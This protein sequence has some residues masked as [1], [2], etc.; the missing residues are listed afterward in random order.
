[1]NG[2]QE[3]KDRELPK[4]KQRI[5]TNSLKLPKQTIKN[6]GS[7]CVDLS[8]YSSSLM[9]IGEK[10][11]SFAPERDSLLK[12]SI[13]S[14]SVN[15][16][17]FCQNLTVLLE[18]LVRAKTGSEYKYTENPIVQI[19]S[20]SWSKKLFELVLEEGIP[21]SMHFDEE[22]LVS[23]VL[24]LFG[25]CLE[26]MKKSFIYII[27]SYCNKTQYLKIVLDEKGVPVSEK[28]KKVVGF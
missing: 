1:M 11:I 16:S 5:V 2:N 9:R 18:S 7:K 19:N 25:H 20:A 4:P 27:F 14:S 3:K 23:V 21:L 15:F 26:T 17:D 8:V 10:E 28:T 24:N 12:S 13:H 6:L 22:I